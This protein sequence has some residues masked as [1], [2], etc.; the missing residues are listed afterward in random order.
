MLLVVGVFQA[1]RVEQLA[2]R[3]RAGVYSMLIVDRPHG[4]GGHNCS[5]RVVAPWKC[6]HET[7]RLWGG[8]SP[9]YRETHGLVDVPAASWECSDQGVDSQAG[10]SPKMATN[11]KTGERMTQ[12]PAGT[13]PT[14]W[15]G[16][17][18]MVWDV[19]WSGV[20]YF[21]TTAYAHRIPQFPCL[22]HGVS[23]T[24]AW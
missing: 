19:D 20:P 12:A 8:Q 5:Q 3:A 6:L 16:R 22:Q 14:S 11:P 17:C 2:S 18:I 13:N 23:S 4:V 10:T 24:S 15:T 9:R 21:S 7:Q 1:H